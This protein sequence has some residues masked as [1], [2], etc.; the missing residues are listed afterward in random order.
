MLPVEQIFFIYL[1]QIALLV[2]LI[3]I[4]LLLDDDEAVSMH[5]TGYPLSSFGFI[6]CSLF[7][8]LSVLI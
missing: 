6:S 4:E 7:E 2:D 1:L 8:A 3:L 5:Y